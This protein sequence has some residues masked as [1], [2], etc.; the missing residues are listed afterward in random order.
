MDVPKLNDLV[1][2]QLRQFKALHAASTQPAYQ[3][4]RDDYNS[5]MMIKEAITVAEQHTKRRKQIED[6]PDTVIKFPLNQ[7]VLTTQTEAIAEKY[8]A[9][10]PKESVVIT[11]PVSQGFIDYLA[12][13]VRYIY[14]NSCDFRLDQGAQK[15]NIVTCRSPALG[16]DKRRA[17]LVFDSPELFSTNFYGAIDDSTV[18]NLMIGND[19][20][21]LP[22]CL[23]YSN[24]ITLWTRMAEENG[25][26]GEKRE[27]DYEVH[28]NGPI[29][30][31]VVED[32]IVL[33]QSLKD[34]CFE[35]L[36]ADTPGY[37][38]N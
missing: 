2:N 13:A 32:L 11:G 3:R 4:G 38:F 23:D 33:G 31:P 7:D 1:D 14:E 18:F 28:L 35:K 36:E 6:N 37:R 27:T 30:N 9:G 29:N 16:E 10:V 5:G 8:L 22:F 26:W 34:F 15:K 25:G 24:D 19:M 20:T 21:P 12:K 17:V